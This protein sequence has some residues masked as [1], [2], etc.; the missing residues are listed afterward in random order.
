MPQRPQWLVSLVVLTQAVPQYVWPVAQ[1][2]TPARQSWPVGQTLP[3]EPQFAR[4]LLVLT[5]REVA[6]Q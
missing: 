4:S 1:P 6:A 3:Q 2:H 5:Q